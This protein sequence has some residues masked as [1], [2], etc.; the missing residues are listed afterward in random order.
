MLTAE[1]WF[2]VFWKINKELHKNNFLTIEDLSTLQQATKHLKRF[3]GTLFPFCINFSKKHCFVIMLSSGIR[4]KFPWGLEFRHN[5]ATSQTS[6]AFA[7][8]AWF[9]FTFFHF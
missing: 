5:R 3:Y 1:M 9:C 2:K 8:T 6:F 7:K 4:R